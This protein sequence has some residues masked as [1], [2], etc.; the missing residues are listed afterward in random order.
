MRKHLIVLLLILA[1]AL[2]TYDLALADNGPHGG[3]DPAT[4]ACAGCH[5]VHTAPGIKLLV[6][7]STAL[8]ESCHSSTGTGADTNVWDGVYANRASEGAYGVV[9]RGLKGG[10]FAN[11]IM[12]TN[13]NGTADGASRAVTSA[14]AFDAT[15]GTVWGSGAVGSGAGA[16]ITL[17]CTNCHNPHGRGGQDADG[18]AAASYRIL[19]A[20]PNGSGVTTGYTVPDETNKTY[21]IADA[22]GSYWDDPHP[23][24]GLPISEW[25]ALC[26]TRYM[27][28]G[29]SDETD[30]GDPIYA[31]RHMTN[32]SNVNCMSCHVAHG[33]S[34][35][36]GTNSG[37]VPWPDGTTS[38]NGDSRSSLLRLDNRGVCYRCHP[39]PGQ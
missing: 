37:S 36:M 26:H 25:C 20:I 30:S 1:V 9:G 17:S 22:S 8:C 11:A 28:E 2:A 34:A 33:S 29:N 18:N 10:G 24:G 19:R 6:S 23:S 5:R 21:T 35:L 31:Y 13:D 15:S 14:H 39:A 32:T 3:Y 12:D 7:T 27:A 4:D 16:S 38:P